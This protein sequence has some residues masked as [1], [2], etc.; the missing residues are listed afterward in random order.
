MRV[1]L[2]RIE[3]IDAYVL[4][5]SNSQAAFNGWYT[6]LRSADWERPQDILDNYNSADLL[7]NGSNRVFFNIGGNNH[8][9]IC[10]YHFG[11]KWVH[12]FVNWIGTHAEYDRLCRNNEQYTIAN[13]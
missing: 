12:L 11:R 1:R 2:I 7:G 8:R 13:F 6:T 3:T 5:H 4:K 10:T 9:M